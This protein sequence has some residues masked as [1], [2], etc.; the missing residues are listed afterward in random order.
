MVLGTLQIRA[1]V[2]TVADI[3]FHRAENTQLR[4]VA[5]SLGRTLTVDG[6]TSVRRKL[7]ADPRG[8]ADQLGCSL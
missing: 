3:T 8:P 6:L 5:V 1:A 2:E 7:T 4:S